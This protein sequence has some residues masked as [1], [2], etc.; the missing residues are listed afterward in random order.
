MKMA[1][2]NYGTIRKQTQIRSDCSHL[3]FISHYP[4]RTNRKIVECESNNSNSKIQ[5]V[6]TKR[7]RLVRSNLHKSKTK[8]DLHMHEN[9][10]ELNPA[11]TGE[12]SVLSTT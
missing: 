3:L 4:T 9:N 2:L 11:D 7:K 5:K 6:K 12:R 10:T 1:K 8:L